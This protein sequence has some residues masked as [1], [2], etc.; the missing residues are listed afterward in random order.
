MPLEGTYSFSHQLQR[1][2]SILIDC[3]HHLSRW[4]YK[5]SSRNIKSA[6][7]RSERREANPPTWRFFECPHT[8]C[9]IKRGALVVRNK[10]MELLLPLLLLLFLV[11]QCK[12]DLYSKLIEKCVEQ[13]NSTTGT[14]FT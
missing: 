7:F 3:P 10:T 13:L 9:K 4:T 1:M 8:Y 12:V 5:L 11:L 6:M 2:T 14:I